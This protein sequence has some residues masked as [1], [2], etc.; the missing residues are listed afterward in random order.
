VCAGS[1]PGTPVKA[2]GC[3]GAF[4]PAVEYDPGVDDDADDGGVGVTIVV[5]GFGGRVRN[6]PAPTAA[7]ST[8]IMMMNGSVRFILKVLNRGRECCSERAK[9]VAAVA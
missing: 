2:A 1:A 3:V 7:T 5:V 9:D 8:V 4:G 6:Q